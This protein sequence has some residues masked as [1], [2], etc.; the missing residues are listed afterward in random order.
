[1]SSEER[2]EFRDLIIQ[3]LQLAEY[4]MIKEKAL[5]NQVVISCD[6][7]GNVVEIPATELLQQIY[8]ETVPSHCL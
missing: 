7:D 4:K 8:H 1:M 6:K 2:K 5:R 3:G